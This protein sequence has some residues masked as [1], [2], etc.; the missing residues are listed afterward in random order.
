M[1][2]YRGNVALLTDLAA[3][4]VSFRNVSDVYTALDAIGGN[5]AFDVVEFDDR[6]VNPQASG[7]RDLQL[8]LRTSSGHVAEFRLQLAALDEVASWEHTL[9]KVRRDLKALAVEQGRSMSVMEQAIWNGD[10]LRGQESFWRAL[11]STLNG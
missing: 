9:Y 5:S 6:F 2:K 3:A 10:L 4:K 8:M 7:Y 11:Q 1:I